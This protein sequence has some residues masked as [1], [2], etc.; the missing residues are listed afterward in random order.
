MTKWHVVHIAQHCTNSTQRDPPLWNSLS[1][2]CYKYAYMAVLCVWV[3]VFLQTLDIFTV[4]NSVNLVFPLFLLLLLLMLL[5]LLRLM[6]TKISSQVFRICQINAIATNVPTNGTIIVPNEFKNRTMKRWL[7]S[8]S[9]SQKKEARDLNG[10][11]GIIWG[12]V[13]HQCDTKSIDLQAYNI[14]ISVAEPAKIQYTTFDWKEIFPLLNTHNWLRRVATR[15]GIFTF[16]ATFPWIAH[17]SNMYKSNCKRKSKKII[18]NICQVT[19]CISG[20][21]GRMNSFRKRKRQR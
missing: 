1:K 3:V 2:L 16:L 6:F 18:D 8:Q 7:Q 13:F 15:R 11:R 21:C 5:L 20:I 9:Q 10:G 19:V 14:C 4:C 17:G 12:S